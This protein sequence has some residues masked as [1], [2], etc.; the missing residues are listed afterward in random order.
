[1]YAWVP[2]KRRRLKSQLVGA[3]FAGVCW[4]L[5][6]MIFSFYLQNFPAFTMYG[7]FATIIILLMWTYVCMVLLLAGAQINEVLLKFKENKNG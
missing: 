4:T 5:F 2:R 3:T 6:S 1:M 7:S